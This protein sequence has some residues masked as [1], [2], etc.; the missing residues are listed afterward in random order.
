M[1][2][3]L[4][5]GILALLCVSSVGA[6]LAIAPDGALL[7]DG[8]VCFVVPTS[9]P[10]V[11]APPPSYFWGPVT[12]LYPVLWPNVPIGASSGTTATTDRSKGGGYGKPMPSRTESWT[13]YNQSVR[14]DVGGY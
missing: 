14:T 9:I 8:G 7:P 12:P 6:Q 5:A 3:L 13:Q 10:L 1:K 11:P 2:R 4:T